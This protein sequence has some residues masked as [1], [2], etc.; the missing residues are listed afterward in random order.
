MSM[1]SV[2]N[3]WNMISVPLL[4]EDMSLSNLFPTATSLAYGFNGGYVT[5][6]TLVGG[7]GYWLKFG[8]NQQIQIYGSA[9]G[10]TVALETGWNM[11][12]AVEEDIPISSNH[13]HTTRDNSNILFRI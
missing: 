8:G 5:E 9:M 12:G 2:N 4:A 3:E 13:K 7:K 6:D 10:D 1:V 11:F